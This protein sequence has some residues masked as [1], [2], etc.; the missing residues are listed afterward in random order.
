MRQHPVFRS[1]DVPTCSSIG[2]SL[3]N[4]YKEIGWTI[5][6]V[7][8]RCEAYPIDEHFLMGWMPPWKM[9][10]DKRRRHAHVFTAIMTIDSKNILQCQD[11]ILLVALSRK[12]KNGLGSIAYSRRICWPS[13]RKG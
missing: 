3:R 8:G 11:F 13:I 1:G 12:V 9:R 5:L 7:R 4:D 10:S 2:T 6:L